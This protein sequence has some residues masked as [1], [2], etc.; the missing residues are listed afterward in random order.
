MQRNTHGKE[1]RYITSL[2]KD[3]AGI[4]SR[5]ADS[6]GQRVCGFD[7]LRVGSKS[8]V[9][10]VNGWSFVKDNNEYYD[11]CADVL[12]NMFLKYNEDRNGKIEKPTKEKGHESVVEKPQHPQSW[13][14]STTGH[15]SALQTILG[16]SPSMSKLTGG[17]RSGRTPEGFS[18]ELSTSTTP[19]TSPPSLDRAFPSLGPSRAPSGAEK[20]SRPAIAI[21]SSNPARAPPT[22]QTSDP[23]TADAPV[24]K[25]AWKLKGM[26]CVI[27]H[28]D[29]TPKQKFKFTFHSKPF[30]DL[31]KGHQ[32]EVLLVGESALASVLDAVKLALIEGIEDREKLQTLRTCLARKGAWPGTKVQIKPMFRKR[33]TEDQSMK[34]VPAELAITNAHSSQDYAIS[35]I[36][37]E[38]GLLSRAEAE[39]RS[40]SRSN[41]LSGIT[42]SR[43]SAAENNLILDKLQLI[44]KWGGEPTHASRYQAQDLGSNM[45]E[46]LLLM[47]RDALENV[48]VFTSSE[49]RVSTSGKSLS[50]YFFYSCVTRLI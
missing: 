19:M 40:S 34:L 24:P 48:A 44:I 4:A 42:L 31:L 14:A 10:D 38:S 39:R 33:K 28:A 22:D 1:V 36:Q 49:R 5:I 11:K 45:R 21:A 16:R 30:V 41:S 47:N 26:V 46:D 23:P 2:T 50:G 32:E 6:F 3:E 27:R 20:L 9:I 7:L 12:K 8:Y 37:A 15:R 18:P 43:I 25:H 35:E 13:K 17:H 29:R